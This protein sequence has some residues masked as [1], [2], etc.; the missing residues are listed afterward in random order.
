MGTHRYA[1]ERFLTLSPD[2]VI[3]ARPIKGTRPRGATPEED[4]R[5]GRELVESIKDRAENLM[6]VDLLRND[7]GRVSVLG[8]VAVPS[9][10]ELET[11]SRVHHLVSAVTGR[12]KPGTGA[13]D[14]LRA[15]FPGGSITGAPKIRSMEIIDKLEA[16]RRGPYCGSIAWLGADGALDANI[17]IRTMVATPETLVAQAGGGIVYD[18]DPTAE[19]WEMMVKVGSLLVGDDRTQRQS[20]LNGAPW[21]SAAPPSAGEPP[22]FSALAT[23]AATNP[24]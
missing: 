13:I 12:L 22:I 3:E 1:P 5:L 15:T 9:L 18:S 19:Y 20:R 2:G 16:A 10:F 17:V 24:G 23:T 7:I 11:F 4:A 14:L 8:S 21:N 6:I